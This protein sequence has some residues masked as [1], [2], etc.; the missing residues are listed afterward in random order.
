MLKK[1]HDWIEKAT[2]INNK[3]GYDPEVQKHV[4]V[5]DQ[6]FDWESKR[7]EMISKTGGS[8]DQ[9][10]R[11]ILNEK[12]TRITKK[13]VEGVF[14]THGMDY[15]V[16]DIGMFHIATTH[17]TYKNKDFFEIKNIK[18]ILLGINFIKG[19]D[20]IPIAENSVDM[21]IGLGDDSYERLEHV[22]DAILR[23]I[24]SDY[25]FVRYDDMEEGALTI[26]RSKIENGTSLAEISKKIGLPKYG[27]I[28]RNNEVN[29]T[30]EKNTK[31][32]CDMFEAFI[33]A[34]YFDSMKIKYKDVGKS[35]E[36]MNLD[37]GPSFSLCFKLVKKL[38]EDYIDLPMLIE[39]ENNYK[40][41][42][43]E[44]YHILKWPDPK[45]YE[46]D[47]ISDPNKMGKKSYK[48]FV[49]DVCGNIIG[50]GVGTSKQK[51]EK[52]AA[53]NALKKLGFIPYNDEDELLEDN[54]SQI[55]YNHINNDYEIETDIDSVA[56][57]I[58]NS[59]CEKNNDLDKNNLV[60]S[61]ALSTSSTS[62]SISYSEKLK[63]SLKK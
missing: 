5:F 22:G 2:K 41:E 4:R 60:N 1:Q 19:D 33:G 7:Q 21:C 35:L 23:Q 49:K 28:S 48:I 37:R 46:M 6:K 3:L 51:A 59:D 17:S 27:L 55:K 29:E 16:Y 43:L 20:L 58:N 45:Y 9:M 30:R 57:D 34:I 54:S 40:H 50:I 14:K 26:L 62:S 56:S 13:F 11:Y 24:F 39:I 25:L 38:I 42:L 53:K 18:D 36:I 10:K 52:L 63:L 44:A 15:K 47:T 61:P 32:Q 8:Q 12:N 31:F